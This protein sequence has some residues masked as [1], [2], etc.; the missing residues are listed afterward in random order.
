MERRIPWRRVAAE[1]LMIVTSILLAFGIDAWWEGRRELSRLVGLE[2]SLDVDF[3]ETLAVLEASIGGVELL[4]ARSQAFLDATSDPSAIPLDSLQGLFA[5]AFTTQAF[6]PSI[7][8]LGAALANGDIARLDNPE[9]MRAVWEFQVNWEKYQ[10]L[11]D[12]QLAYATDGSWRRLAEE[13]GSVYAL[14][15]SGPRGSVP[16]RFRLSPAEYRSLVSRADV[17]SHTEAGMLLHA[18]LRDLL[19]G[20]RESLEA[21]LEALRRASD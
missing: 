5:A 9:L 4:H 8:A 15:G 13:V 10:E 14:V 2:R 16:E 20:I 17:Y 12:R 18:N 6:Q 1:G 19:Y 7:P 21:G 11:S 3:R